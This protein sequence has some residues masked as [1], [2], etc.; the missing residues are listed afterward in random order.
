[1]TGR[2]RLFY[3][4]QER[5]LVAVI[6]DILDALDV[7]GGLPLLPELLPGSAPEPGE[8]RLNGF[9]QRLGVH[10]GHHQNFVVLPVL[11]DSGYQ[12]FIVVFKVVRYF[13]SGDFF[14]INRRKCPVLSEGARGNKKPAAFS[15]AGSF[16]ITRSRVR[17]I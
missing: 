9:A 1:M 16:I 12:A 8:A 13:H 6:E 10:I 11:N 4:D 3:L 15:T 7:T 14:I 2:S 5:V 17:S